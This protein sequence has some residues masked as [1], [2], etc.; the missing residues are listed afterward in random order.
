MTGLDGNGKPG[1]MILS[2]QSDD[3][4]TSSVPAGHASIA[5]NTKPPL[6]VPLASLEEINVQFTFRGMPYHKKRSK[7]RKV[8]KGESLVR[9][10]PLSGP[11]HSLKEAGAF[12]QPT[13]E[14]CSMVSDVEMVLPRSASQPT[15]GSPWDYM[16]DNDTILSNDNTSNTT[17]KLSVAGSHLGSFGHSL[18]TSKPKNWRKISRANST[19]WGYE[20]AATGIPRLVDAAIRTMICD[21]RVQSPVGIQLTENSPGPKLAAIAPV[22]FSPGYRQVCR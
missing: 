7:R 19:R 21:S 4:T 9:E 5:V 3:Q 14:L 6:G 2:L 8:H 13:P 20:I 17:E 10:G 16:L 12:S 15:T 11:N 18:D 22:L 1:E